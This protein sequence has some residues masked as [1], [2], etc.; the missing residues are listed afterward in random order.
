MWVKT[1]DKNECAVN[2][3][4]MGSC[5]RM[6]FTETEAEELP[7]Y[8]NPNGRPPYILFSVTDKFNTV[9][10]Q[11][12]DNAEETHDIFKT[13]IKDVDELLNGEVSLM[14]FKVML[15]HILK[16]HRFRYLQPKTPIGGATCG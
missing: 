8:T 4:N 12:D 6:S 15:A 3:T 14:D 13:L 9:L 11:C 16:T 7:N 1:V 5:L 10:F 2:Y